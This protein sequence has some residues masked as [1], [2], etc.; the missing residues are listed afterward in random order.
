MVVPAT[1]VVIAARFRAV[2]EALPMPM[3]ATADPLSM[4]RVVAAPKAETVVEVV[5]KDV[6]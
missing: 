5:L 2:A 3:V 6:Y 4:P 1:V